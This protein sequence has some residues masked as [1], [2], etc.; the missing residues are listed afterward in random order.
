MYVINL[1]LC[2][3]KADTLS[4][5]QSIYTVSEDGGSVEIQMILSN[6]SSTDVSIEVL[7]VGGTANGEY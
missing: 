5:S 6:S 3:A 1:L 7:S 2:A 4:F